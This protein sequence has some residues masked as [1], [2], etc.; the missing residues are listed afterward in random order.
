MFAVKGAGTEVDGGDTAP[1]VGPS[2]GQLDPD[3]KHSSVIDGSTA[4]DQFSLN[5]QPRSDQSKSGWSPP[6]RTSTVVPMRRRTD[7][8]DSGRMRS[9]N[10]T[11]R[12]RSDRPQGLESRRAFCLNYPRAKTGG[13][14]ESREAK[15]DAACE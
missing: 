5:L 4:H 2:E 7:P 12:I 9:N 3:N 1:R 6:L 15:G 8:D 10:E 14:R 13:A 11:T